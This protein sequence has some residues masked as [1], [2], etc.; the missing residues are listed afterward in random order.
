MTRALV[1]GRPLLGLTNS[2]AFRTIHR[3]YYYTVRFR[4][5]F[6]HIQLSNITLHLIMIA[7]AVIIM[8]LQQNK[9]H[10]CDLR[11]PPETAPEANLLRNLEFL[12]V[13]IGLSPSA[14]APTAPDQDR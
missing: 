6:Y 3:R 14:Y 4:V 10:P 9:S 12:T 5:P 1:D 7:T 8:L 2:L 11:K 13:W